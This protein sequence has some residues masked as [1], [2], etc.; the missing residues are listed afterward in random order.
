MKC[1]YEL[2]LRNIIN[3]AYGIE[4]GTNHIVV[5]F[6]IVNDI[7]I[8]IVE[9]KP[10]LKPLYTEMTNKNGVKTKNF[11][12]RSGNSSQAIDLTEVTSYINNRFN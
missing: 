5:K 12:V 11:Y 8:C 3:T 2:H 1:R 10:G 7:E 9:I 4:F 6:P